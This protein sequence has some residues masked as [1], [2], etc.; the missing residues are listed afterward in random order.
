MIKKSFLF[1]FLV[2]VPTVW[3]TT[4]RIVTVECVTNEG[5]NCP[6]EVTSLLQKLSG[7]SVYFSDT[8]ETIENI[9]VDQPFIVTDVKKKLLRPTVVTISRQNPVYALNTL[10]DITLIVFENGQVKKSETKQDT[11]TTYTHYLNSGETVVD[12]RINTATHTQLLLLTRDLAKS[13]ISPTAIQWKEDRLILLTLHDSILVFLDPQLLTHKMAILS[14]LLE[15]PEY[16][17][18]SSIVEIDLRF[19]LPVLRTRE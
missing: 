1:L 18:L 12:A 6:S 13:A 2:L 5:M 4:Q 14:A 19:D 8:V 10:D 3:W 9:L 7:T 17:E 11:L 15:S 16:K